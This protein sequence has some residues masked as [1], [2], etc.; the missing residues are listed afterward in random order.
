M[1]KRIM[2]QPDRGAGE[3]VLFGV[4]IAFVV[5]L[6]IGIGI[7][8]RA[9]LKTVTFTVQDK[10]VK[11]SHSDHGDEYQIFTD[12]GVYKD[13]DTIFFLKFNSSDVYGQLQKGHRY[14]CRVNGFRIPLFS[15][16]RNILDCKNA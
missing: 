9:T 1:I 14:T 15:T 3:I 5:V 12:K 6:M 8:E 2:K 13:T 4:V 7:A 10:T 16:K 11:R